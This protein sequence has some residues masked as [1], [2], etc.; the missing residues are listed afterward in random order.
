MRKY[1]IM[2]YFAI[3]KII[4]YDHINTINILSYL[5]I[6]TFNRLSNLKLEFINDKISHMIN[7]LSIM[8]TSIYIDSNCHLFKKT[9]FIMMNP[10]W[11]R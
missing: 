10:Y 7:M 2:F 4:I 9:W 5:F 1:V 8:F 11:N 6:Y 3:N